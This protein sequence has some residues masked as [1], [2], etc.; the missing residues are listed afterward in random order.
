M[1]QSLAKTVCENARALLLHHYPK[2]GILARA[3]AVGLGK[4]TVERILNGEAILDLAVIETLAKAC[5][6]EP[7]KVLVANFDPAA[8]PLLADVAR[9]ERLRIESLR[10]ILLPA[11]VHVEPPKRRSHQV[12]TTFEISDVGTAVPRKTRPRRKTRNP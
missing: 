7:W 10:N 6:V 5:R 9:D 11:S 8:P 4:G 1:G 12:T 2:M 3:K